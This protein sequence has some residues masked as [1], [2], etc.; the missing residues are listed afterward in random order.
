M[1]RS[2]PAGWQQNDQQH[3]RIHPVAQH[4]KAG[5]GPH[6]DCNVR[7]LLLPFAAS[8][9]DVVGFYIRGAPFI[10]RRQLTCWF[11][12]PLSFPRCS[13]TREL[14]DHAACVG[15][16]ESLIKNGLKIGQVPGDILRSADEILEAGPARKLYLQKTTGKGEPWW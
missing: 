10:A 16:V 2:L 8:R 1:P 6:A 3:P 4:S 9:F 12:A 11:F 7:T 5:S 13:S 14:T 15:V